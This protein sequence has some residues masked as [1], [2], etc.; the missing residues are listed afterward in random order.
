ML[1]ALVTTRGQDV[2]IHEHL[3]GASEKLVLVLEVSKTNLVWV[4]ASVPAL[5][6]DIDPSLSN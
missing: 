5:Q 6:P 1:S 3:E 4:L 2:A